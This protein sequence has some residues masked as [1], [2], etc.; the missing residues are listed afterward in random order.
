MSLE[1]KIIVVVPRSKLRQ[2]LNRFCLNP[3]ISY[4]KE[5]EPHQYGFERE[6]LLKFL[7]NSGHLAEVDDNFF[8]SIRIGFNNTLL[9][10]GGELNLIY[11]GVM[12]HLYH[13]NLGLA[14]LWV[15]AES[16]F[17]Q[18]LFDENYK[19]VFNKFLEVLEVVLGMEDALDAPSVRYKN[20]YGYDSWVKSEDRKKLVIGQSQVLIFGEPLIHHFGIDKLRSVKSF[21][22][23]EV[24]EQKAIIFVGGFYYHQYQD[25]DGLPQ[26]TD[27]TTYQPNISYTDLVSNHQNLLKEKLGLQ[28]S[29]PYKSLKDSLNM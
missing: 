27:S 15:D 7:E 18:L 19:P 17:K 9:G 14:V 20:E 3:D 23:W 11:H 29:I 16:D 24:G 6:N 26:T 2:N 28:M 21:L 25:S 5:D 13:P 4:I 12:Q 1:E 8:A 10:L 22:Q